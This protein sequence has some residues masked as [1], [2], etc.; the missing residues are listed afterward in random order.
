MPSASAAVTGI[1]GVTSWPSPSSAS[2]TT[3]RPWCQVLRIRVPV[4]EPRHLLLP[5]TTLVVHSSCGCSCSWGAWVPVQ[6][7]FPAPVGGGTL[8]TDAAS[9]SRRRHCCSFAYFLSILL[10]SLSP[11]PQTSQLSKSIAAG[12]L[13]PHNR[14]FSPSTKQ[15]PST[16]KC[17]AFYPVVEQ[18]QLPSLPSTL[19]AYTCQPRLSQVL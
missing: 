15:S 13:L 2:F 9:Q 7:Q 6:L 19:N 16:G 1:T 4:P 10:F 18:V 14:S 12:D 11:S 17:A 8:G 5:P 3:L